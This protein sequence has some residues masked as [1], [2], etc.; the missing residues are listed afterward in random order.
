MVCRL[1]QSELAFSLYGLRH[2]LSQAKSPSKAFVMEAKPLSGA[3]VL[4]G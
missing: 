1:V 3:S 2:L 4:P